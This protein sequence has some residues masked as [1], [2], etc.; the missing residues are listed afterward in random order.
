MVTLRFQGEA[1]SSSECESD[2]ESDDEQLENELQLTEEQLRMLYD[3][4]ATTTT[5]ALKAIL[6][7]I[8]SDEQHIC[9]FFD[10]NT[11]RCFKGNSCQLSHVS[12]LADG[13]R[14][15]CAVYFKL[16]QQ[17]MPIVGSRVKAYV[18]WVF[19]IREFYIF[20][21][22][23]API[24]L[25]GIKEKLNKVEHCQ[26]YRNIKRLLHTHELVLVKC[27]GEFRRGRVIE[28]IEEEYSTMVQV[29]LI[30]YGAVKIIPLTD[31]FEWNSF[32][33]EFPGR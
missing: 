30:D 27:D 7:Y 26:L 31:V 13:T 11:G 14:D 29:F 24:T 20:I 22:K 2:D 17:I 33:D 28:V 9:P 32:C 3:E 21:P 23:L 18:T 6:G 25:K 1:E 12:K 10:E 19:D 15:R 5:N 8:P 16:V 4:P